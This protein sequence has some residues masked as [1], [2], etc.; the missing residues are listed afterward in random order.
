MFLS[1]EVS[2][3]FVS[4]VDQVIDSDLDKS[5]SWVDNSLPVSNEKNC[6]DGNGLPNDHNEVACQNVQTDMLE[7]SETC[8]D[9]D[10]KGLM[11][12]AP[13]LSEPALPDH[14]G[15]RGSKRPNEIEELKVDNKKSR[16]VIIDSDDETHSVKENSHPN[17]TNLD[18]DS[19]SKENI[20]E[21]GADSIPLRSQNEKFDC[22]ACSKLAIEV[23]QHPLLKVI[24]C[25]DC[26]SLMEHKMQMKVWP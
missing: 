4:A 10:N 9:L 20:G 22:T 12:N 6:E 11:N 1:Q 18:P 16:T 19:N 7:A 14:T 5:S 25:R 3:K 2:Q 15:P 23:H 17:A 8:N 24:I 13:S 26:K 21:P